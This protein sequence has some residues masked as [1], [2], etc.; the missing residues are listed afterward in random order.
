MGKTKRITA[1]KVREKTKTRAQN[2]KTKSGEETE[3][4]G[5]HGEENKNRDKK[6]REKIKNREDKDDETPKKQ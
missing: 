6:Q 4:D 1:N 3:Q 5:K 2:R